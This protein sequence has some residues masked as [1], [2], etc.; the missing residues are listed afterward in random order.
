MT[1]NVLRFETEPQEQ[2]QPMNFAVAANYLDYNTGM[3]WTM[4]TVDISTELVKL[5]PVL[6][7]PLPRMINV[8]WSLDRVCSSLLEGFNLTYCRVQR[9]STN[10]NV[11]INS[12]SVPCV[13]KPI[14]VTIPSVE[15]RYNINNLVPYSLYKVEM[16]MFSKLKTGKVSDP[17]IISTKEGGMYLRIFNL[18]LV[19]SKIIIVIFSYTI[20]FKF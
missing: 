11:T 20:M 7:T 13:E 4:C 9:I 12:E 19:M 5:E 6:S 14:T 10:S 17:Q 2:E 8:Q 1:R 16:Y 15:K 18:I 3:H